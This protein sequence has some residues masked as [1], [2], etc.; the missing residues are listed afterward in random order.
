[1]L[2]KV[3]TMA[4]VFA[5]IAG[6]QAAAQ[7]T[8][9]QNCVLRVFYPNNEFRMT[10]AQQSAVG[11]F[12]QGS[13]ASTVRVIGYASDVGAAARNQTLSDNRA[14]VAA[15][16]VQTANPSVRIEVVR[17]AGE[18]GAGAANRRVDVLRDR[19][20]RQPIQAAGV[21]GAAGAVGAAGAGAG[22]G[23]GLGLGAGLGAVGAAAGAAVILGVIAAAGNGGDGG[24]AA[25]TTTTT[26]GSD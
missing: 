15:G 2:N 16:V 24:S 1:M 5:V 21:A 23:L 25:T 20:A 8:Q 9:Q 4:A 19:C 11:A 7:S 26:T 3:G 10:A 6:S 12:V 13:A 14:R 17:G 22:A 18:S